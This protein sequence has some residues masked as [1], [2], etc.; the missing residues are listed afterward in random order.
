ET[1]RRRL[2]VAQKVVKAATQKLKSVPFDVSE[3]RAFAR[4]EKLP[5]ETRDAF[6][7]PF[8]LTRLAPDAYVLQSFGADERPA[9]MLEKPDPVLA[10]WGVWPKGK[11]LRYR[12]ATRPDLDVFPAVLLVGAGSVNGVWVAKLF[13]DREAGTRY[14]VVR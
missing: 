10:K 3:L 5:L 4:A 11:P 12:Y 6:G 13:V 8:S 7:Q 9:T 14:L 1:T 2:E